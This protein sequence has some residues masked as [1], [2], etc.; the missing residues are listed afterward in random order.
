M[1]NHFLALTILFV[2]IGFTSHSQQAPVERPSYTIEGKVV[3]QSSKKA[4]EY[5][6]VVLLSERDSSQ[7]N[8]IVSSSTGHFKMKVQQTGNYILSVGFIG[9]KTEYIPVQITENNRHTD[10]GTISLHAKQ[11]E[12]GEVVVKANEH[13]VEYQIDKKVV[14]VAEQYS[15]ISGS[16]VDI[17]E[18]V[19]SVQVDIEGNISLRGNSN[20]TVL[21]DDRPTVL[22]AADALQQIPAGMI[23]NIEIITNPSAKYDPEGTGGII[24]IITKKRTLQ[25]VSGISHLNVGLDEKYGGD[26][27]LNYR[28]EEFN[29]F[30]GA[31]YN[32]RSYPGYITE[33]RRTYGPDTTFYLTADGDRERQRESYSMRGGIEW[34]PN[35]KNMFNVQARYGSRS[36]QSLSN[37]NYQE[38]NSYETTPLNYTNRGDSERSGEFVSLQSNY[39]RTFSSKKHKLSLE[40]ML[41]QHD[42]EE[43]SINTL[44]DETKAI[45]FSQKS[46]EKG[47]SQGLRY[48]V[49][50]TQPFTDE[51]N[52]EAGLQ[53]RYRDSEESNEM[54][55]YDS[56]TDD[57]LFQPQFSHEVEY[58]RNIHAGYAL[59]RG[60][61]NSFGYQLGLRGEYTYRDINL[62]ESNENFNID[63]FDLFPTA[64]FSYHLPN[65][66][67]FMASYSRRIDRPRGWYLEPFYTW[68]DAYNIRRGNPDLEPEYINSYE[69]GYQN[70]FG[71]NSVSMEVYYRTTKNRIERIRSVYDSK[72]TLRTYENVGTDYSL[73]TELMV[74]MTPVQWWESSLTGNFYNYRVKGEF[75]GVDFDKESFTWSLR[76]SQLFSLT[77]T[78]RLEINPMYHSPEV[79]AQ[80]REEGFFYVHGAVRQSFMNNKLNVTLQVRDI[81][82]TGKH[83]S[84]IEG[85]NFYNYRLYEHEAPMVML[86]ITWRINNYKNGKRNGRGGDMNGMDQG[87]E[88]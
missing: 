26:F 40:L 74:N 21:I 45:N 33:E 28:T 57:Y 67:Q 54:F 37:T 79:E 51:F 31:D 15:A 1:R 64:H 68:S 10:V 41:Y 3:D 39:E 58:K 50:Y 53:G 72:V 60:E 77:E 49:N 38:W 25:G 20:F 81:F 86:N 27:L 23:K 19:P 16:A 4:M 55:N 22:E 73:G 11:E 78:T 17:L 9:F 8:G 44:L 80:E 75:N 66:Q 24:N 32:K 82:S 48:R 61:R 83:E 43:E 46:T 5:A 14:H 30:V 52:L 59:V 12:L 76:W 34:S 88:E 2:F 63:R 69:M 56:A 85:A 71:S 7:V 42:G 6:T 65:D 35:D 13:D 70:T 87:M 47:P 18:N 36:H 62:M 84:T 29:F